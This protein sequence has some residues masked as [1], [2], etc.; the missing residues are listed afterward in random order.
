VLANPSVA[1]RR[2]AILLAISAEQVRARGRG[3][4]RC[5]RHAIEEEASTKLASVYGMRRRSYES[6]V[7][8]QCR[9]RPRSVGTARPSAAVQ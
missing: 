5:P 6:I 2:F 9:A 7:K 3:F 4:V 1:S 8:A